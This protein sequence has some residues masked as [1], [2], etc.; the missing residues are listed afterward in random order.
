[1]AYNYGP[2]P[3]A[4]A[5]RPPSFP[6]AP[7]MAPPPGMDFPPGMPMPGQPFQAPPN[8]AGV[9]FSAPVIRLGLDPKPSSTPADRLTSNRGPGANVEPLGNRN[10]LGLGADSGRNLERDRAVVRESMVAMQPP[11]REEVAR[12]IFVG[13]IT[14]EAPDDDVLEGLFACAG[15]FRRWTRARDAD[16]K[17]CRFGFAEYEDVESLEAA[18]EVFGEGI[19]VPACKDGRVIKG[20]DAKTVKL[21]VVVDEQSRKYIND[22]MSKRNEGEDAKEFRLD[23]ARTEIAQYQASLVNADAFAANAAIMNGD[24]DGDAHMQYGETNGENGDAHT[25]SIALATD[26]DELADIPED[27]R[28][29]VAAE[30]KAF[31]DR[32]NRRDLDRLRKEEEM[33]HQERQKALLGSRANRL[34]SPPPSGPANGVP[35]G[36]RGPANAPS[37]PKSFRGAQ[38]PSDY[39]N[40][41]A[42]V[43]ANG[44]TANGGI[45][46][47]AEDEDDSA[48]DE[49]LEARRARKRTEDL[50]KQYLD[51]ER[52]WLNRE[53][54]SGTAREREREHER[55]AAEELTRTKDQ[56]AKRFK[57]WNDDEET[58]L[59]REEYYIDRSAWLRKRGA[60]RD[61]EQR[62]DDADR[63]A[64]DR[65][66][67]SLQT[68][69]NDARGQADA[70][71][72]EVSATI[73]R[74]AA[75]EAPAQGFKLSLG[76][77][78]KPAAPAPAAVPA[79]RKSLAD[80]EGLLEDE[81]DAAAAGISKPVLKPLSDTSTLPTHGADLSPAD[82]AAARQQLATEIP[83]NTEALFAT[84]IKYSFLPDGYLEADIRPSVEKKIIDYVGVQ[85]DLLVS[86][87]LEGIQEKLPAGELIE[88]LEGGL[89]EEAAVLVKKVWRMLVFLGECGARVSGDRHSYSLP[90]AAGSCGTAVTFLT[91]LHPLI[92]PQRN[93]LRMPNTNGPVKGGSMF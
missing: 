76:A 23:T 90:G 28:P 65:R 40:G 63:A 88:R 31:R 10:R 30:I 25:V 71:L 83:M 84:P 62:H 29:T 12:T 93:D 64:E 72:D 79:A 77:R 73:S 46:I 75:A 26:T 45:S 82:R 78:A 48:S 32:S 56:L 92:Q 21:M 8:I 69:R 91:Q 66:K 16:D 39:A 80:V 17:K 3:G 20:E 1:M 43:G 89:E 74:N 18:T 34:A 11:T 4:Y 54:I 19:E 50:E 53:R 67:A 49:E 47:S 35:S 15:K 33:E 13:N 37:G 5:A 60:Y 41:V 52:R 38:M 44:T 7:G 61:Q 68:Q 85:D 51:Q 55:K 6:P 70:F 58:R 22:W 27:M 2:P 42:F 86:V 9:D 59:G 87:V 14:D 81:E 57:E 24:Q 36:P